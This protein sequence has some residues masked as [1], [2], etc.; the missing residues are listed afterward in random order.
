MNFILIKN[1]FY[2]ILF[3]TLTI[4][5]ISDRLKD[6]VK[7]QNYNL[8][9]EQ[10]KLNLLELPKLKILYSNFKNDSSVK[11]YYREYE[12][13]KNK[14]EKVDLSEKE[15]EIFESIENDIDLLEISFLTTIAVDNP[16]FNEIPKDFRKKLIKF[17]KSIKFLYFLKVFKII[18]TVISLVMFI[19]LIF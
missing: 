13:L 12:H 7:K 4:Y 2:F 10:K 5:F 19:Y 11:Y 15:L 18:F 6:N 1:I 16:D 14:K 3:I 17:I 8:I 9:E